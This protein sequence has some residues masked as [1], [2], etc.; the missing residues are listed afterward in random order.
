MVNRMKDYRPQD[1]EAKWQNYWQEQKIYQAADNSRQ[2]K[3]YILIEFP[4]PSGEGLHVGHCLS[5]TAMDV[6]ARYYRLRGNNVLYP[7]GWDAFGLPAENY[8]IKNKIHP[9]VAIERNIANFKR[10]IQSLGISFDWSR[11]INTTDPKYYRWTQW[12]FLQF[13]QHGLAE[14]KEVPIN[15]CPS[16]K[17]G[18][19]FEEVVDGKC[20][21]CGTE[22][23][24]RTIKQ[25]ILKITQYADRLIK[26]L[27]TVDYLPHIKEQQINWIGRSEGAEIKFQIKDQKPKSKNIEGNK[28]ILMHGKDTDPDSKWYPWLKQATESRGFNVEIPSLPK[29][30]NPVLAEWIDY[31]DK[32]KPNDDTVLIG[33]SRGG[34]AILRWLERLTD[35]RKVKK[36]ILV[37][38][39]RGDQEDKES[40]FYT[41]GEYNFDQIKKHC[42]DF[43]VLHSQDDEWVPFEA[44]EHNAKMLGAKFLQFED[45]G[46]FG[47]KISDIPELLDEISSHKSQATSDKLTVFT[48]RPDTIFG[49]TFLVLAPE[50]PLIHQLEDSIENLVEVKNYIQQTA[51]L[52]MRDRQEKK[53]KTGIELQGVKAV[54]PANNQEL[55]IFI[56]DYVMMNYGTGAIMAVPAHDQRDWEFAQKRMLSIVQVIDGGETGGAFTGSGK[57]INS[58][59]Y[60]GLDNIK[61]GEK[62]VSDLAKEGLAEHKV[63]YKL[64]DWIFS[65]QHYWG[66][67]IPI[68]ICPKCGFVP[69]AEK[70]L[71][72][73]LPQVE[74]Y[75]PTDTGESPLAKITDWVN[76]KCPKCGEPAKRETDTMPNW[77]GSSWYYL[78]YC[79]PNNDQQFADQKK[80]KYWLPVDLYNGGMEHTTL[81]LLYSRFWHKFLFDLKLVPTLEP[82]QRR[83]SHGM[84]L[85]PDGQKMSKSRGNVINPDQ[86][87]EKYGADTLRLYEMFMGEYEAT[88]IWNEDSLQGVQRFLKRIWQYYQQEFNQ[89]E[90][91]SDPLL[92]QTVKKVGEDIER[93]SFNTAVSSLMILLNSWQDRERHILAEA[94]VMLKLLAP[95]APH[96]TEELWHNLGHQDSLHQ[97]SWPIYD[98]KLLAEQKI[99]IAVQINGKVRGQIEIDADA[100][101]NQVEQQ[102]L[103]MPNIVKYLAGQKPKRVLYVKGKI[104]SIVI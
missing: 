86:I 51:K 50:H 77:A 41:D 31:L 96:L 24:Q 5:Y 12:I 61:G 92:H 3:R 93:R 56:A 100:S 1:F 44:G 34:V 6:L 88:K 89:T 28:I 66:E 82:Y 2:P 21:R 8:A 85:G 42:D 99:I 30:D 69:V 75:Q 29:A 71:P 19:A 68:I 45:R 79:D 7:M 26:D 53:E 103:A 4:Y 59:K 11:E 18:L 72:V 32:N 57:M 98:E 23:E 27:D 14:K 47:K 81:H 74:Y 65:R 52:T 36:V 54:N 17:I 38:T 73:E 13:F 84:I 102:A 25:W 91:I 80:L 97:Q 10:Q 64:H 62:V 40:D 43:V 49:A 55:P 35:D 46:H 15:W 101:E 63:N 76:V 70:D 87:V 78:R 67:P 20:E 48:T 104:I 9:S 33:H 83:I 39:N 94:E 58:G 22:V 95:F 90:K 16:C 37:A 60:N